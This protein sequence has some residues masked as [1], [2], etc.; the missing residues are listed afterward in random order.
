MDGQSSRRRGDRCSGERTT[1]YAR[2]PPVH[3]WIALT[4]MVAKII[5]DVAHGTQA[6]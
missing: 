3:N 4:V 1:E 2:R 5:S 6:Y